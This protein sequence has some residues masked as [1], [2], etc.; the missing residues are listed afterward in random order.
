MCVI[1]YPKFSRNFVRNPAFWFVKVAAIFGEQH[2]ITFEKIIRAC[3][4]NAHTH[5]GW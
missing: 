5:Q 2:V 4:V 3:P 1:I